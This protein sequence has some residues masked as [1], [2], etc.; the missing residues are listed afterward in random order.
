MD[1]DRPATTAEMRLAAANDVVTRLNEDLADA[2]REQ[3][4]AYDAVQAERQAE[5]EAL[6]AKVNG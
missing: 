3:K 4:A 5:L 2:R 1:T 6:R